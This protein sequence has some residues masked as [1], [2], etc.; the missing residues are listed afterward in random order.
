[1]HLRARKM[2]R[3]EPLTIPVRRERIGQRIKIK[4]FTLI[5]DYDM[6]C[7]WSPLN[8]NNNLVMD[9]API[10]VDNCIERYFMTASLVAIS[11]AALSAR[12]VLSA[13]ESNM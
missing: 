12:S 13:V 10:A 9:V 5:S 7:V 4:S 8:R 2:P 3:P 11:R 6:Q 1:M